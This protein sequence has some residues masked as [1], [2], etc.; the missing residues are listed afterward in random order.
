MFTLKVVKSSKQY[1]QAEQKEKIVVDFDLVEGETI[2][3]RS[4]AFELDD[5]TDII[6]EALQKYV[7]NYNN[8]IESAKANAE[9]YAANAKANETLESLDGFEIK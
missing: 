4:L 7:D 8:E 6:K 1:F 2:E 5:S 3:P 9:Q